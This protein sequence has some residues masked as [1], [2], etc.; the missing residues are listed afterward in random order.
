MHH[1]KISKPIADGLI[2]LRQ[3]IEKGGI[4][5]SKLDETLNLATWNIREFG[6][7]ARSEAVV[8]YIAEILGQLDLIGIVELRD[9]LDDR[10]KVLRILGPYWRTGNEDTIPDLGGNRDLAP[11]EERGGIP[12]REFLVAPAVSR[13]VPG[14]QFRLRRYHRPHPLGRQPQGAA[15][16]LRRLDLRQT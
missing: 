12:F 9:N 1:G 15:R 16:A 2:A 10:D 7:K 4:P 5:S 8:H 3:R 13:L 6:K 11:E 14:R